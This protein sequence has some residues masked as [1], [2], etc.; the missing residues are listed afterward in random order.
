MFNIYSRNAFRS[1]LKATI[2]VCSIALPF[3]ASAGLITINGSTLG[4]PTWNRPIAG[5]PNLS[6]T[7][8]A[9]A[10]D[11]ILFQVDVSTTYDFLSTAR[12]DNYLFLY[13][14]SFDSLNQLT[15]LIIG[16][17]DFPTIGLSGFNGVAL[18]TGVNYF[19][20]TSGFANDNFGDFTLT[21]SSNLGTAFIPGVNDVPAPASLAILGL[22]LFG[23]GILRRRK[24]V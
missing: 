2:L 8:T 13:Q 10:Y 22:A 7:G 18:L 16:N 17:D 6:G 24:K 3:T 15:N 23:T 4:D 5:G 14:N 19:A 9:V 20:V 11:V 12:W 1:L 21:I